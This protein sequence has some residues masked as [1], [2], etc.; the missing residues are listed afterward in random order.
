MRVPRFPCD[1]QSSYLGSAGR[2]ELPPSPIIDRFL[3]FRHLQVSALLSGRNR[4]VFAAGWINPRTKIEEG[5]PKSW[6]TLEEMRKIFKK[7]CIYLTDSRCFFHRVSI[8]AAISEATSTP[9]L[10]LFHST[11][12]MASMSALVFSTLSEVGFTTESQRISM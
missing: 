4:T 2:F 11:S 10:P 12:G 9:A 7:K 6:D 3:L 5:C 1:H 8:L